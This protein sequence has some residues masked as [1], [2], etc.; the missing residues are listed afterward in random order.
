MKIIRRALRLRSTRVALGLLTV[1]AFLAAFGSATAP[2]DPVH[3]DVAHLLAGPSGGHWLGTDYLGRDV[4]SRLM[5]GTRLSVLSALEAVVVGLA[6]GATTGLASVFLGRTFD[7]LSNRV[8]DTLMTLPTIVFAV[9]VTA[10]LGNRLVQAMFA[11][12]V[13]LAPMFFRVTRAATLQ[14]AQAQYVEVAD[15][16]GAS[17][18][19]V[20]R[21]HVLRKVM[22]TVA[23]TAASAAAAALLTVSSLTF[24]GIG[25]VPPA[26]TWGGVLS[27]D[28]AYLSLAP[29]APIAPAAMI[30][31]T[32]GA[33]NTLADSIRDSSRADLDAVPALSTIT[34]VN[35]E[36]G[37]AYGTPHADHPAA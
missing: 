13:L 4:L 1:I 3:Q 11:V 12:G 32:V 15:L 26:P 29:W 31:I 8:N 7:Y 14:Y 25:V 23:V 37:H 34:D 30:M 10:V 17:R 22:P 35:S 2:Y 33:L 21:V 28:L 5:A 20:I 36:Y 9:A 16:L 19:H 6:I 27:S 18:A 24:L